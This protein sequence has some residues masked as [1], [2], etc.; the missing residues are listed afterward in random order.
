[1]EASRSW[2][3][4]CSARH[5]GYQSLSKT[6]Q[7]CITTLELLKLSV[8]W[9]AFWYWEDLW[10]KIAT[11][12]ICSIA[13]ICSIIFMTTMLSSLVLIGCNTQQAARSMSLLNNAWDSCW[14]HH[15]RTLTGLSHSPWSIALAYLAMMPEGEP[16]SQS[17]VIWKWIFFSYESG[18]S[19]KGVFVNGCPFA[20]PS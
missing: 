20:Y 6:V 16:F 8:D 13:H 9:G 14:M 11:L 4:V 17:K 5:F 3:C 2:R 19:P 18:F 10:H 15:S 12:K 1:M 7:K